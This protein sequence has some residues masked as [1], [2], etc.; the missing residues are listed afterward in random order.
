MKI[1]EPKNFFSPKYPWKRKETVRDKKL[2]KPIQ[3]R[4]NP[5]AWS[6]QIHRALLIA[7]EESHHVKDKFV[8]RDLHIN[9][10]DDKFTASSIIICVSIAR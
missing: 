7:K 8:S 4:Y 10:A 9:E 5:S 2:I 3:R 6:V 1:H